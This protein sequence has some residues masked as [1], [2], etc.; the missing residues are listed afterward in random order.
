MRRTTKIPKLVDPVWER[1][2]E[3]ST[4]QY[5]VFLQFKEVKLAGG[6]MSTLQQKIGRKPA[7]VRQLQILSCINRW[8]ER[9]NAY[10]DHLNNIELEEQEKARREMVRRQSENGVKFQNK[11]MEMLEKLVGNL[12][13][14]DVCRLIETGVKMERIARGAPAEITAQAPV[15]K[16]ESREDRMARL[17]ISMEDIDG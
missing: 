10:L 15:D 8:T 3:E 2:K 5:N 16:Y 17:K 6:T 4:F 7:F 1:Q 12:D 13:A 11:A 9:I 14:D